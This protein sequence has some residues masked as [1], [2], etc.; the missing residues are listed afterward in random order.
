VTDRLAPVLDVLCVLRPG[1]GFAVWSAVHA[2]AVLAVEGP[3][4]G[5]S[6]DEVL[7]TVLAW[8]AGDALGASVA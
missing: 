2:L 3:A 5:V 4:Q 7:D 8:I 6:A 1:M